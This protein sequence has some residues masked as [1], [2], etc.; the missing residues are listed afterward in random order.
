MGLLET[1]S[2]GHI[3]PFLFNLDHD[4]KG[5][6]LFSFFFLVS[7]VMDVISDWL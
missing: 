3:S 5:L 4:F 1:Q 2:M 7:E 6:I